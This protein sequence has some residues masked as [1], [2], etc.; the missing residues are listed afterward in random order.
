MFY[1]CTHNPSIINTTRKWD[2]HLCTVSSE[3][4][5]FYF[6]LQGCG[7]KGE[8]R[9]QL[10]TKTKLSLLF[11]LF[12]IYF[13]TQQKNQPN[14]STRYIKPCMVNMLDCKN[15]HI[16]KIYIFL[17]YLHPY[18]KFNIIIIYIVLHF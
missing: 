6:S 12:I 3:G 9:K 5:Y 1:S 8:G 4:F 14:T 16:P 11:L 13:C 18:I 7:I 10:F 2:T 17:F 15:L